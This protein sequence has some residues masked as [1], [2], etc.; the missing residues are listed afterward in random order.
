MSLLGSAKKK[1]KGEDAAEAKPAKPAKAPKAPK[2]PKA[3]AT[4]GV[5]VEKPRANIY[6][7]ML[8]LSLAAI[9]IACI[10]LYAEMN[11]Y[12]WKMR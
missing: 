8:A 7:A 10:C 11:A 2:A 9:I 6:T 4:R 5:V 12:E 3:A 1:K